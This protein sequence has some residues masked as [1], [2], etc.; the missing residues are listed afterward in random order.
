M[1]RVNMLLGKIRD[2]FSDVLLFIV[3]Q[4]LLLI[5]GSSRR[6][7]N[8]LNNIV[9]GSFCYHGYVCQR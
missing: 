3:E 9:L 1:S 6:A 7:S 5:N 2:R 4:N 8:F